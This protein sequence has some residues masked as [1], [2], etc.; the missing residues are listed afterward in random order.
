ML[1]S[2]I[3]IYSI[4]EKYKISAATVKDIKSEKTWRHIVC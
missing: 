2:Q 1:K 3:D 4:S